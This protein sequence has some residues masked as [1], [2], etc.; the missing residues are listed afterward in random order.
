MVPT[1]N[2][3]TGERLEDDEHSELTRTVTRI[4]EQ[5]N[6]VETASERI[7][8]GLGVIQRDSN[9]M[10]MVVVAGVKFAD[11]GQKEKVTAEMRDSI[12]KLGDLDPRRV[13]VTFLKP[14]DF[15]PKTKFFR[16]RD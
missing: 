5:Y 7:R 9:M 1:V 10:V 3:M 14:E 13:G 2:V 12:A 11:E 6:L 15:K 8:V 16:K 4:L